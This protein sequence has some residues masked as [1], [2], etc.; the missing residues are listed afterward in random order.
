MKNKYKFENL[1]IGT[2]FHFM[3]DTKKEAHT[4]IN[5]KSSYAERQDKLIDCYDQDT[6]II[7]K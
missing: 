3:S 7:L 1:K 4:K 2:R 6:V 5:D